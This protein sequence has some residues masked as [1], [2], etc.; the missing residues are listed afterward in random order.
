MSMF[1]IESSTQPFTFFLP[2]NAY[3]TLAQSRRLQSGS[4]RGSAESVFGCATPD[5]ERPPYQG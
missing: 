2:S 5:L 1:E 3:M 4:R